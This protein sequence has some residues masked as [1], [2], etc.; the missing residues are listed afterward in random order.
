[1][2]LFFLNNMANNGKGVRGLGRA[3][4]GD[5]SRGERAEWNEDDDAPVGTPPSMDGTSDVTVVDLSADSDTETDDDDPVVISSSSADPITS[6][7]AACIASRSK[8]NGEAAAVDEQ[9]NQDERATQAKQAKQFSMQ[10]ARAVKDRMV[11]IRYAR[12]M[13]RVTECDWPTALKY[14]QRAKN[15]GIIKAKGM[16]K[17]TYRLCGKVRGNKTFKDVTVLEALGMYDWLMKSRGSNSE[18]PQ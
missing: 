16:D 11:K 15:K 17:E 2:S 7:A 6:T 13:Q 3:V 5:K 8:E 1:L 9:A 4:F 14:A 12:E 18:E 10:F